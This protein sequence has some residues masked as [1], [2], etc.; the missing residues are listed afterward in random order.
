MSADCTEL[1]LGN[2]SIEKIR[3]FEDFVNLESLWI[4]GNKLKKINN[5]DANVRLKVKA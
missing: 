5:L 3:G 4:N 1:F 2:K